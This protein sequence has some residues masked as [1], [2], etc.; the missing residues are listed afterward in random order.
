MGMLEMNPEEIVVL[1][2][3]GFGSVTAGLVFFTAM[4]TKKEIQEIHVMINSRM[5]ELLELT[6]AAAKAAGIAQAQEE[7]ET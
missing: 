1:V 7:E 3:A 6:A 4:N 5:D 2:T